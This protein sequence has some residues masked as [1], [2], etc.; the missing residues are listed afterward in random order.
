MRASAE[1]P[2][3]VPP[4]AASTVVFVALVLGLGLLLV[5]GVARAG[6]ALG[7]SERERA[8]WTWGSALGIGAFLALTG[9]LSG[10]GV[11]QRPTLPPPVAL[12]A[13]G[14]M[15]VAIAAAFSPLGTRLV[16]GVPIAALVGF[17]AFR[18]PLELVLHAWKE[19]GVLPVQMTYEG[20]NF[21]IVSGVLALAVGIA[22]TR[23]P[24]RAL[25]WVFNAVGFALL[26]NV[27]TIALRSS[28]L[29]IRS[30]LNDPP[31]LL[32]FHFP[33]GWIVPI[34]VGGAM[35]GHLLVFRWL[36]MA[37]GR[38][39]ASALTGELPMRASEQ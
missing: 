38:R 9:V 20:D 15:L 23:K 26:L 31:V 33:Y 16:R 21:D 12:F 1:V 28:P 29:P 35:F 30:Y 6:R 7:E 4:S 36:F 18:L 34:C 17:Q 27:A 11:L 8:R 22:L 37:E 2:A 32:A 10:S 3:M 24:S 14:S 5:A 39:T 13:G 25:V 19:Q